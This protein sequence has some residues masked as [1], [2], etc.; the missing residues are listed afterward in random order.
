MKFAL[1]AI[2]F[3]TAIAANAQQHKLEKLWQTDTVVAVPESVLPDVKNGILYISLIDGN[4]W[5]ADGKGGVGKLTPDGKKYNGKWITGLNAPKGMGKFGN[6]LYVADI[7]NVVIVDIAK[8][9]IEKKL[10]IEGATGLNDITV[11]DNGIV[12]V[13]DSKNGKIWRIEK[14]AATLYLDNINGVNGLKSIKSDLFI[15]GGKSFLKANAKKQITKIAELPESI[16]GIEPVGNGDFLVTSW[17]GYVYYV[18][19]D[20]KFE[21]L[22]DTRAEKK[23]TADIG[24]DAMK[25]IVYVPTFNGKIVAAYKLR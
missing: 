14:D 11:T 21:T 10:P 22:L 9:K 2:L 25:K 1:S 24:Y 18:H 20:G 6:R 12:Y 23:N 4:P 8:G 7:S 15:G 17:V 3:S 16:D 13:S 5:D 19:P